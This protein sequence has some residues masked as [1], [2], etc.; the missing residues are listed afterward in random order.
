MNRVLLLSLAAVT[1]SACE[2]E[3]H[4]YSYALGE[5]DVA[6]AESVQVDARVTVPA[7]AWPRRDEVFGESLRI[8]LGGGSSVGFVGRITDDPS[9]DL[10][11]DTYRP[12]K[13]DINVVEPFAGCD[14]QSSC[15]RTFRFA[16]SCQHEACDGTVIADAY[17][18]IMPELTQRRLP[19]GEELQLELSVVAP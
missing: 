10:D 15:T 11:Y 3:E 4:W 1:L 16:F 19:S 2:R 13:G 18:S 5:V 8:G 14:R 6:F 12:S 9:V 7:D 17:I